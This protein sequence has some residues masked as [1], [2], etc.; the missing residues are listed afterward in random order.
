M[1][2]QF[3]SGPNSMKQNLIFITLFVILILILLIWISISKSKTSVDVQIVPNTNF[4]QYNRAYVDVQNDQ[5]KNLEERRGGR[6][7]F[8]VKQEIERRL[9]D[10][11]INTYS[12]DNIST[13]PEKQ[14]MIVNCHI[15]YGWGIPEVGRHFIVEARFR[16]TTNI[17]FID[18][19][20]KSLICKVLYIRGFKD[21]QS[22]DIELIFK[23]LNKKT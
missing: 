16:K 8:W 12:Y 5:Y 19:K 18:A 2:I 1:V 15:T 13:S 23:E 9:N 6:G 20:T 7:V 3:K 11:G 22:K 17:E 21:K 10:I 14:D 4:L